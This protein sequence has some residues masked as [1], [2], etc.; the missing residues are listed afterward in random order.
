MLVGARP[1]GEAEN[2]RQLVALQIK[3]SER[4]ENGRDRVPDT[5]SPASGHAGRAPG[6]AAAEAQSAPSPLAPRLPEELSAAGKAALARLQQRDQQVRQEEKAHAAVAGDLAGPIN[7]VYQRGP[8]G[9]Q[10]AVGGS[11]GIQASVVSGDPAEAARKA[12]RLAA[13][14]NAATNPS[15][16]DYAVAREAYALGSRLGEPPPLNERAAGLSLTL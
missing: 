8:D 16:Q 12:G 1:I 13:A 2:G 7:Y 5:P 14:A 6:E 15:A 10:Y 9:R 4:A 11:V 3:E